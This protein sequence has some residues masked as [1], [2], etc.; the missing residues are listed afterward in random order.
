MTGNE[1]VRRIRAHRGKINI[2][3]VV[4]EDVEYVY[5]E[6]RDLMRY[7]GSFGERETNSQWRI[8]ADGEAYIDVA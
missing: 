1:L 6:K 2:P 8:G 3:M 7:F 4:Y 5:A